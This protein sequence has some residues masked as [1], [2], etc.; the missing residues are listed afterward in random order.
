MA[1]GFAVEITVKGRVG[2]SAE[3]AVG[4]LDIEVVPRHDVVLVASGELADLLASWTGWSDAGSRSTGSATRATADR[5][6]R[7]SAALTRGA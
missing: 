4:A 3:A 1:A 7:T 2:A 6:G 5:G